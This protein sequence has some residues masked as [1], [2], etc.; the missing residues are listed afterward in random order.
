M[1]PL[2]KQAAEQVIQKLNEHGYRAHMVGGAVRDG[3]L[4][5]DV[6]DIDVTTSAKPAEIC[7]LFKKAHQMNTEHQTVLVRMNGEQIEV[8]TERGLSLAED[9]TSRDFT[10]NSMAQTIDGEVIDPCNGQDDLSQKVIR[11]YRPK[12]RMKEDPLRML[13][14]IRFC[15]ELSFSIDAT[16]IEVMKQQASSIQQVAGERMIAEWDKLLK[17]HNIQQAFRYLE[18]T[19]LY[20]YL[21]G[22]RLLPN[23][24][25]KLKAIPWLEELDSVNRWTFYFLW[26]Q[27]PSQTA[28]Q[29]LPMSNETKRQ[30]KSRL[31]LFEHRE[32][33][34]LT[35]WILYQF[36]LSVVRD[37]EQLRSIFQKSAVNDQLLQ[38]RWEALPIHSSK[39]LLI[40][41][42]DLMENRAIPS[43]PWI[44]QELEW[45]EQQ[46][47]SKSI[48]HSKAALIEAIERRR[49]DEK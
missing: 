5:R 10:I 17:G 21:P 27:K 48:T 40:S 34:P 43:G 8:T 47:I 19:E 6:S 42:R 20:S 14:A 4:R 16:L 7:T 39:E 32:Q 37:V 45:L 29:G 1:N 22:L 25:E 38:K 12:E 46:V 44:K 36:G 2:A 11:S 15:S 26:I 30:I 3:L 23:E 24:M 41:G 31:T 33:H 13:R 9:L 18:Q 49:H 28:A 35:D